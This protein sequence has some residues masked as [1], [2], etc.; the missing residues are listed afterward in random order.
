V[1]R[2]KPEVRIG[3]F[4]ERLARVLEVAAL[5]SSRARIDVE[6]NSVNDGPGVHLPNSLHYQDLAIDLDT[7]GDK[8]PDTQA[9]AEWLR[10]QLPPGYD[11]LFEA[12]H[13]HVEWDAHRAPL[14][15]IVS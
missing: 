2:F 13:V 5:W 7:V 3:F 12:N 1:I 9:L 14:T 4:D 8:Q 11:V 10:V 6:I 15:K